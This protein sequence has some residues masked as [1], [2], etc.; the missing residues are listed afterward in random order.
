MRLRDL[1]I[2][3]ANLCYLSIANLFIATPEDL[4]HASL[5]NPGMPS[6]CDSGSLVFILGA[7]WG[8]TRHFVFR[9]FAGDLLLKVIQQR[10]LFDGLGKDYST[11]TRRIFC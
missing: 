6:K 3:A 9:L 7:L 2:L 5:F 4:G 10:R 1:V 8:L 11:R